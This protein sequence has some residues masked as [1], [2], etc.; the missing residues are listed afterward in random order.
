MKVR[1]SDPLGHCVEVEAD[2]TDLT[3]VIEKTQ[4]LYEQT[5]S[6]QI[7]VTP[8]FAMPDTTRNGSARPLSQRVRAPEGR[9][10][11]AGSPKRSEGLSG[12][13]VRD[14]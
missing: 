10:G 13:C 3:Y 2:H 12:G 8:G 9:V 5:R 14:D 11:R 7:R 4:E 1:I 6:G